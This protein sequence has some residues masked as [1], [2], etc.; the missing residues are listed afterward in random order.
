MKYY[1]KIAKM[2]KNICKSFLC[3]KNTLKVSTKTLSYFST[4]LAP[5][6]DRLEDW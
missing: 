6:K 1:K 3:K 2:I 5:L 4:K